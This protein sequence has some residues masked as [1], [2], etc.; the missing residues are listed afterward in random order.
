[1]TG[2]GTSRGCALSPR[3]YVFNDRR[4]KPELIDIIEKFYGIT[5]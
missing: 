2:I 3:E 1:M 4:T 5:P